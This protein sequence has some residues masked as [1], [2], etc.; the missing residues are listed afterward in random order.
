MLRLIEAML[1]LLPFAAYGAWIWAGRR[2]T[3][4]LLW[5]TVGLMFVMLLAAAYLELSRA[6]PP[7]MVYVPPH[8]ENG[9]IVPGHALPP[10][11]GR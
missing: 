8:M 1:F 10:P 4:E 6:I 11:R 3:R 2:Y 5:G 9:R 7:D